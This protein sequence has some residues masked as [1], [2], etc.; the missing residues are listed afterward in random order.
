MRHS[1]LRLAA[2]TAV[3][4]LLSCRDG[5]TTVPPVDAPLRAR[6]VAAPSPRTL[7]IDEEF[8]RIAR[9]VIPGFAGEY[10][11]ENGREVVMLAD[12][13]WRATAV[14]FVADQRAK[15]GLPAAEIITRPARYD[16]LRLA[17]WAGT[18]A[19]LHKPGG[20]WALDVDEVANHLWIAVETASA[21]GA[22]RAE[23]A[24]AGVPPDGYRI[25]VREAPRLT[26]LQN[27]VRPI[28]GGVQIE[29]AGYCT[30][31]FNVMV[32]GVPGFVTASHCSARR[33]QLDGSTAT[34]GDTAVRIGREAYDTPA[35]L[36]LT[37]SGSTPCR[38]SEA[39]IYDY[40]PGIPE[41]LGHIARTIA[42]G[43][44]GAGA[45]S[46]D[47]SRPYFLIDRALRAP[48]DAEVGT[49]V[50]KVGRTTGWTTGYV[51]RSCVTVFSDIR[52]ECQGFAS[53]WSD[54]GDSG[55]PVFVLSADGARAGLHGLAWAMVG[56]G[57]TRE[58]IYS[59]LFG[60]ERDFD[61]A[62]TVT[63]PPTTGDTTTY[64]TVPPP[65]GGCSDPTQIVC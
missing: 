40:Y 22:V 41:D 20:M 32:S 60:I 7:S 59:L 36:C 21:A 51:T 56:D 47:A 34:Q 57:S 62:I 48:S 19:A 28:V 11:D 8:V 27:A 29:A 5:T 13:S 45:I 23:L 2:F 39:S 18:A 61:I 26:T 12:S 35:W 17:T 25:D 53:L 15:A 54:S 30:L 6:R 1:S 33:N 31:G 44:G 52:Y 55:A 43:R 4:F 14:H 46:I 49:K 3:A 24:R 63:A 65:A 37:I 50:E 16:F 9:D 38:Y 42:F 64:D 10:R 58:A